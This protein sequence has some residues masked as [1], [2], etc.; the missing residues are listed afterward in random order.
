M[1][2]APNK[3]VYF[4]SD[5]HLGAPNA[6]ASRERES[7]VVHFL[8]SIQHDAAAVYIVGDIFDFWFEYKEVVPKGFIRL[9]GTL[10]KLSDAGVELHIF[11]GNHDLWMKDYLSQELRA[12]IYFNPITTSINNK[13][14][15]IGH[16][17]G[18]GPGDKGFK[19][20]KKI[21]T[22]PFC[23]WL[24]KWLHPDLGIGLANYFSRKSRAK[25]GAADEVYLGDD[26]EWLIVYTKE[27]CQEIPAHYFVF[28]HRHF[29]IDKKINETTRYINLGDWIRSFT[30][31]VFDGTDMQLLTW[32]H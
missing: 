25:T 19:F 27:K 6:L 4:L 1:Q 5:F 32:K 9:L 8:E 18:L 22:N 31:A 24:F 28:G 26:N 29:P 11:T 17:D 20:L 3:K 7:R 23:Q 10:S 16:G 2:L 13:L 14:F 12:T 30:Y 15:Y 21:F